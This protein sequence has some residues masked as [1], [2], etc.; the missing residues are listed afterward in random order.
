MTL[1]GGKDQPV[2]WIAHRGGSLEA[3]ENT[4]AAVEHGVRTGADWQEVDVTLSAD[5]VPVVI[6][7]DT[8]ERTTDGS[9]AVEASPIARL[10]A[11]RAG[12]PQPNP[13]TLD[14][15]RRQSVQAPN[16]GSR[17]A[18]ERLPSLEAVLGVAGI[19]PMLELKK[20]ARIEQLAAAVVEALQ[21]QPPT[22][23]VVGSFELPLLQAVHRLAPAQPLLGIM[24]P[25]FGG[26]E[27]FLDLPLAGLAV[28][29]N[30]LVEARR[31]APVGLPIWVWTVYGPREARQ[32]LEAG[33]DG[34]ITDA[35]AACLAAFA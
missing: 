16:F 10:Q 19:C 4:V 32:L 12:Q 6:H 1:F 17:F 27:A 21:R 24:A 34:I 31:A 2:V 29:K 8:L 25:P 15:L 18:A 22:R 30:I 13:G 35:P 5:G 7:D 9:G 33:A 3:P 14:E 26:L 20:T 11:L 23:S 28:D